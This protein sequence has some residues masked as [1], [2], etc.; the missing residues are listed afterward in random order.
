VSDASLLLLLLNI[1]VK[2]IDDDVVKQIASIGFSCK[3]NIVDYVI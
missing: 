3:K 1:R 2:E